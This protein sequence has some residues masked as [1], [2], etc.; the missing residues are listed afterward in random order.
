[1]T[2]DEIEDRVRLL[3]LLSSCFAR[4]RDGRPNVCLLSPCAC[5]KSIVEAIML[6]TGTD[7]E[8]VHQTDIKR[9][10]RNA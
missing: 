4:D 5:A 10:G 3:L 2:K 9:A 1:M 8:H 6:W 7:L